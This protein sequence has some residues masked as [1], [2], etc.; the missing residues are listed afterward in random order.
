MNKDHKDDIKLDPSRA[1]VNCQHHIG[2]QVIKL[3]ELTGTIA[4]DQSGRS[5]IQSRRGNSYIMLLYDYNSN[6]IN[7]TPIKSRE[8][9]DLVAGYKYLYSHLKEGGVTPQLHKLDNNASK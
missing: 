5:P 7:A 9:N 1:N 8:A 4:T 2:V 6:V 3:E